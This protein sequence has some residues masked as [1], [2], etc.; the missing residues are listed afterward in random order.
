M[1][2]LNN[3]FVN[4]N[5]SQQR[6]RHNNRT[7]QRNVPIVCVDRKQSEHEIYYIR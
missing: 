4:P 1:P 3:G 6:R 5:Y 7:S 2:P